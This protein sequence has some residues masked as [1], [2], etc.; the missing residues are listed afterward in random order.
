MDVD[1]IKLEG[2]K[3][4]IIGVNVYGDDIGKSIAFQLRELQFKRMAYTCVDSYQG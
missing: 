1:P 3:V 4:R 2:I